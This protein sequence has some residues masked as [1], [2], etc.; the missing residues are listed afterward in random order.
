MKGKENLY[1]I[2]ICTTSTSNLHD[3]NKFQTDHPFHHCICRSLSWYCSPSG[4]LLDPRVLELIWAPRSGW[5][6]CWPLE[7]ATTATPELPPP[8]DDGFPGALLSR[9]LLSLPRMP[10]L[11]STSPPMPMLVGTLQPNGCTVESWAINKIVKNKP[12]KEANK[13]SI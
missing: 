9:M 10:L 6:K 7:L 5:G 4:P 12:L 1:N 8:E 11:I 2:C 13:H 3:N